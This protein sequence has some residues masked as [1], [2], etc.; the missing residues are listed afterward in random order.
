[1]AKCDLGG[2]PVGVT[3]V[4]IMMLI[5]SVILIALI[6]STGLNY[7]IYFLMLDVI[8]SVALAFYLNKR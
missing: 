1:M 8:V 5:S 4:L 6:A 2:K 7:L 3:L